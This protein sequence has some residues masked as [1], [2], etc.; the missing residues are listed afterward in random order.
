MDAFR[1]ETGLIGIAEHRQA[2]HLAWLGLHGLRH[3]GNHG[4]GVICSDGHLLLERHAT[5]DVAE[6]F[7][8]SDPPRGQ[9]AIGQ[10]CGPNLRPE[11]HP[12][13]ARYRE[14]QLGLALSGRLTNGPELRDE[15]KANG[16]LFTSLSDAELILQ[17]VAASPQRTLV[18]RLVDTLWKVEGSYAVMLLSEDR[19]VAVRD[20]RGFR[21]LLLGSVGGAPVVCT[22]DGPILAIGGEIDREVRAG[23]M[24]I[25]EGGKVSSVSPFPDR[26]LS[27]CIHEFVSVARGTA[28]SM[29]QAVYP[30]RVALGQRLAREQ[31]CD[32]AEV[33][34]GLPGEGVPAALGYARGANVDYFEAL[35]PNAGAHERLLEPP[36]G[37]ADFDARMRWSAVPAV[38][39]GKAVVLVVPSLIEGS[40]AGRAIR[41]LRRA[42]AIEV[43]LRVASPPVRHGCPYGVASPTDEELAA[44]KFE[45]PSSLGHW[46]EAA[47]V[48]FLSAEG[49]RDIV[50]RRVDGT[51]THCAGCFTG[52]WP[53]SPAEPEHD[54]LPLFDAADD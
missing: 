15:L 37:L 49:L 28:T 44:R 53:V 12:M 19:L 5:G 46:L 21:P 45:S 6:L 42:G 2:V 18:N 8:G 34:V 30:V 48:G 39:R 22:E 51:P 14:G 23:E 54:Q 10:V 20:P 36:G 1:D 25:I 26:A 4:S 17:L 38:V 13:L 47:S 29:G 16:S 33:V 7:E 24:I 27:R 50:G 11:H 9:L 52:E 40:Q 35:L 31:P 32:T 41:A 3:R 43:H